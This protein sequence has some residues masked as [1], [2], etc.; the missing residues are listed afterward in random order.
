M[1][2][3][4]TTVKIPPG[5]LKTSMK[6]TLNKPDARQ[7]DS[8][9]HSTGWDKIVRIVT[10]FHLECSVDAQ[11]FQKP[12]SIKTLL[13]EP[14]QLGS[15]T[16]VRLL[17]SN[18]LRHWQDITEDSQSQVSTSGN[19][20]HISTDR[21]GWLAV[22]LV[23][24]DASKIAQMAMRSLSIEPIMLRF[25]AY[26]QTFP[27]EIIQIAVFVVP[28][29]ANEEPI[30]QDNLK[31]QNP[32]YVPIAF[33]HTVQAWPGEKLHFV[34]QGR[35]APDASAGEKDLSCEFEVQQTHNRIFEKWIKLTTEE[36]QSLS[37]KLIVTACRHAD[38][39]W[40][41]ITEINLSNRSRQ[42]SN[43]SGSDTHQS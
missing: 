37:G 27:D 29:K 9:L 38:G 8:V 6:I 18:Y 19:K 1:H 41:N 11:L 43:S 22:T 16:L 28:C 32:A 24:L 23:Q 21:T 3:S 42:Y 5:A 20:I 7:L 26:C 31:P 36:H 30:H 34:L 39:E 33:P 12:I 40:E 2:Y 25:S 10:A 17:Q 13:P 4:S 15:M 14:L 35:F